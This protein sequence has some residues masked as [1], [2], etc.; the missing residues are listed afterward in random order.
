MEV[1]RLSEE[2]MIPTTE[3]S[4]GITSI[5]N[6]EKKLYIYKKRNHEMYKFIKTINDARKSTGAPS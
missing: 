6:F 2:A 5:S 4:C 3:R 1:S